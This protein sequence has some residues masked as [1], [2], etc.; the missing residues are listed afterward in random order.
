M[1]TREVTGTEDTFEEGLQD[2]S[3]PQPPVMTFNAWQHWRKTLGKKPTRMADG[4]TTTTRK[5]AELW[6]ATMRQVHGDDWELDVAVAGAV[7]LEEP[8]GSGAPAAP[9][10]P[11][12]KARAKA[13][14][15]PATQDGTPAAGGEDGRASPELGGDA[16]SPAQSMVASWTSSRPGS[17]QALNAR[18]CQGMTR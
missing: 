10:T 8:D 6:R 2:G 18:I 5:E 4:G 14:P 7:D 11:R 15:A 3:I 1:T 12:A 9:E 16:H 17:P 13:M